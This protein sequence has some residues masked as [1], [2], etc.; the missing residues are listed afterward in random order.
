MQSHGTAGNERREQ[1]AS[2][3]QDAQT[4]PQYA[5]IPIRQVP[6]STDLGICN[7][8]S[9]AVWLE[10]VACQEVSKRLEKH[11][12]QLLHLLWRAAASLPR[13]RMAV[14]RH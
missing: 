11:M 9:S 5:R 7:E 6:F 4:L 1:H 13:G 3:A 12:L 2:S 10:N 8:S 14:L